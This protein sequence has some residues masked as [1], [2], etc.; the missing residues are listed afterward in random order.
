MPCLLHQQVDSLP[1]SQLGSPHFLI[2][3]LIPWLSLT[4]PHHHFKGPAVAKVTDCFW[5]PEPFFLTF[6]IIDHHLFL[7]NS[8]QSPDTSQV[9]SWQKL[10]SQ[11]ISSVGEV[12]K[13]QECLNTASG[14]ENQFTREQFDKLV[15]NIQCAV[16]RVIDPK[17][18]HVLIPGTCGYVTLHGEKN[19]AAVIKSMILWCR[20]YAGSPRWAQSNQRGS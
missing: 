17:V 14:R 5:L 10:K 1:L 11:V 7:T 16:D 8:S 13:W 19:F 20:E 18:S 15:K 12:G 2:P 3:P 4:S 9:L 6:N